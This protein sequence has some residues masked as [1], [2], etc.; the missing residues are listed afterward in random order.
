MN[1]TVDNV[2]LESPD[3][4]APIKVDQFRGRV[5]VLIET[6]NPK[7]V[8]LQ[9]QYRCKKISTE[10]AIEVHVKYPNID[11]F[12]VVAVPDIYSLALENDALKCMDYM[13]YFESL[14]KA[15]KK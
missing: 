11:K 8:G 15:A 4:V 12:Q 10:E 7:A 9:H 13:G 1:T 14:A 6:L 5:F 3:E 2:L